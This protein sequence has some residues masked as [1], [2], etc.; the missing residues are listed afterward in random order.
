MNAAANP[1][2]SGHVRV[3]T[4]GASGIGAACARQFARDGAGLVAVVD[5]ILGT[6]LGLRPALWI[7]VAGGVFGSI[8]LLPSP[9]PRFRMPG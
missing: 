8:L 4:G 3:V 9:L 7:A 6:A 2:A 5:A 1:T